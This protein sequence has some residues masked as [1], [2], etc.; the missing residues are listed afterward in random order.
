MPEHKSVLLHECIE[1]LNIKP[2]GIYVDGT[3]GLGGHSMEIAKRLTT[4][5]LIAID[6]DETAI[7]RSKARLAPWAERITFVHG[8]FRSL[9]KIL[10]DLG[11][12]RVN[13]MLF[14]LGVSSPQ[15][16][17][18]ERGFSYMA[19]APL[20]MRMDQSAPVTAWT[21]VNTWPERELVR[22]LRDYGEE[23]YA[24][25][26]A[27]NIVRAREKKPVE[28]TLE[29]VDII[30]SAMPGAAL[31]EKQHPAKR[32]F[33]AIR[34]AVNDEL[35]AEREMLLTAMDRLGK[36]LRD[37]L[38][39]TGGSDRQDRH[40]RARGRLHLPARFPGVR[41]RLCA[42]DEDRNEAHHGFGRGTERQP[43]R[44]QRKTACRRENIKGEIPVNA[45]TTEQKTA[46]F[47]PCAESAE[48]TRTFPVLDEDTREL[49]L[50]ADRFAGR[51]WDGRMEKETDETGEKPA[52]KKTWRSALAFGAAAVAA[53]LL[54]VGSLTG[55]AELTAMN[56]ELVSVSARI[57]E[58]KAEER[59]L[60]VETEKAE[61]LAAVESYAVGTLGMELPRLDQRN[62]GASELSDRA[63][64]LHARRGQG[65]RYFW[66]N[67]LDTVMACF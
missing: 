25:R 64:V 51:Y 35:E 48:A 6:Q 29:L 41:V 26:I 27:G 8:N 39:L 67:L 5:R 57:S 52:R 38:P 33:Q 22:I 4:G 15:L 3:L 37:Q 59:T 21:V 28:T 19:D 60:L 49:P 45:K 42:D 16:D 65:L 56:D 36:T 40:P 20:D 30:K 62:T 54:L 11:I 13:G 24:N 53:M 1:N 32:S 58:L 47:T 34:I 46:V 50:I 2:D 63:T 31:R 12:D 14:D 43:A 9:G 66:E 7:E 23:R 61:S 55:Q 10:D 18:A 44:A 17:E